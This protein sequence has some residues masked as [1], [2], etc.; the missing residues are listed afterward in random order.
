MKIK[1]IEQP[2]GDQLRNIL[3][4]LFSHSPGD[5]VAKPALIDAFEAAAQQFVAAWR[6][7]LKD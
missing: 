4:G 2:A 3:D 5:E 6:E 1:K 7:Y